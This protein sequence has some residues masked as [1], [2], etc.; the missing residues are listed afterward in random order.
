[1]REIKTYKTDLIS[2]IYQIIIINML[3]N[4]SSS[5]SSHYIIKSVGFMSILYAINLNTISFSIVLTLCILD[6]LIYFNFESIL[7]FFI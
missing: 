1:M 5:Y 4:W 6:L 2:Q 7:L 3:K